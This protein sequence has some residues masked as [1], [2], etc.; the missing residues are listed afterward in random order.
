[1]TSFDDIPTRH[2]HAQHH[3]LGRARDPTPS[4]KSI[5]SIPDM[6]FE[7]SYL[8]SL[9]R[10]IHF[11]DVQGCLTTKTD[12]KARDTRKEG[13]LTQDTGRASG[14]EIGPYGVPLQMDWGSIVYVTIRNQ[15]RVCKYVIYRGHKD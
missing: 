10:F 12:E 13:K 9:Q 3:D 7:Q 1:M 4:R 8:I 11:D 2:R 5:F 6:R 15:V 14:A